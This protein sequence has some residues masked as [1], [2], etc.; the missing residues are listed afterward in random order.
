MSADKKNPDIEMVVDYATERKFMRLHLDVDLEP[1][2]FNS[3]KSQ[4]DAGNFK[5][6]KM[7]LDEAYPG[8]D[9]FTN[10]FFYPQIQAQAKLSIAASQVCA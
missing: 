4:L 10:V 7:L 8:L 5:V 6:A 3:V 1:A 2:L 9:S